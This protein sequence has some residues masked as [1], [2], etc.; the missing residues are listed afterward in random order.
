[1]KDNNG[2]YLFI[3][4]LISFLSII[5]TLFGAFIVIWSLLTTVFTYCTPL[6]GFTFGKDLALLITV[7][8]ILCVGLGKGLD[9]KKE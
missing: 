3:V 5:F 7:A 2:V 1:M 9:G 8:Y 6:I 4:T